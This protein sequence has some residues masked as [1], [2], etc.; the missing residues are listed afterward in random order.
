MHFKVLVTEGFGARGGIAKFNRDF[1]TALCSH[2]RCASVT[3]LPRLM[4][5]PPGPLPGKLR[6]V[7]DGLDSKFRYVQSIAKEAF[8][9]PKADLLFCGHINLL[10]LARLLQVKEGARWL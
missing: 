2:P 4:P 9:R 5:D 8:G 3:A 10:P 1:L 6:Y 7:T